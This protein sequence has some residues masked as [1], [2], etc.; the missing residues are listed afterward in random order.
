M[1][2]DVFWEAADLILEPIT[3][4]ETRGSRARHQKIS[5]DRQFF[6]RRTQGSANE[7]PAT[8]KSW[9]SVDLSELKERNKDRARQRL[10]A[11]LPVV[12]HLVRR[13]RPAEVVRSTVNGLN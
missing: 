8:E 4:D 3:P 9:R 10:S 5:R 2:T 6:L 7:R 13:H 11:P 1:R 12:F